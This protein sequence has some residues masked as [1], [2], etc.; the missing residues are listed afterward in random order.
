MKYRTINKIISYLKI[1]KSPNELMRH[2][3]RKSPINKS[4][5]MEARRVPMDRRMSINTAC[6]R[7]NAVEMISLRTV[8]LGSFDGRKKGDGPFVRS[9]QLEGEGEGTR[10]WREEARDERVGGVRGLA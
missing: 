7:P 2:E 4:N 1:R 9:I 5:T 6:L 10:V 8:D 3:L